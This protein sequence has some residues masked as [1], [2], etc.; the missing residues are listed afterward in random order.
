MQTKTIKQIATFN[1]TPEELYDMIMNAKK[2]AAFTDGKATTSN[3]INGKF[4]ISDGY[5]TGY[6]IK[7][8]KGKKIVQAWHFAEDGWPGDHFSTC[9]FIFEKK[10]KQTKLIFTQTGIPA[11]KAE[12]LKRGWKE[13]YWQPMK[14]ML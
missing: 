11:H 3:K 7:L 13:Y 8:E 10:G 4:S 2:H 5:I 1:T 14:E 6:N 12:D 9:T